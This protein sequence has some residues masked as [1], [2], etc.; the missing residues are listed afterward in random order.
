M[1]EREFGSPSSK[2]Y[3]YNGIPMRLVPGTSDFVTVSVD[4][5]P[6]DFHLYSGSDSG[7]AVYI[8]ESPYHGDLRITNTYAFDGSPPVHL[9]TDSG[10]LLR[11][12]GDNCTGSMSSFSTGCFVKD[13]ALGTLTGKL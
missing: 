12:H 11:I 9:I 2:K 3:T 8:N 7:E 5:S 10:L 1:P 4:L 13:G 6:S